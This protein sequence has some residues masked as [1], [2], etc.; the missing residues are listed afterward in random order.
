MTVI[1]YDKLESKALKDWKSCNFCS[2]R[3]YTVRFITTG[4]H[5]KK[6]RKFKLYHIKLTQIKRLLKFLV[7]SKK[8]M[9][10][11]LEHAQ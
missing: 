10:S 1:N 11:V 4:K 6:D 2:L 7:Q 8:E 5:P 9:F 3:S